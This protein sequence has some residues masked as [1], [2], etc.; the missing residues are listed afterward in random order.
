M[1][2]TSAKLK[3]EK[4]AV[5]RPASGKVRMNIFVEPETRDWLHKNGG[6]ATID[7]LVFKEIVSTN[8]E[9]NKLK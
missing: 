3:T 6:S 9:K 2:K 1:A 4:N 8:R 5:G 7:A